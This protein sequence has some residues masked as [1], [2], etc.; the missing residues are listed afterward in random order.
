MSKF[1]WQFRIDNKVSANRDCVVRVY[2]EKT[3]TIGHFALNGYTGD[4]DWGDC[5]YAEK[6]FRE[7]DAASFLSTMGWI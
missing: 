4:G 7:N 6:G 3:D 2:D 1:N 5:I